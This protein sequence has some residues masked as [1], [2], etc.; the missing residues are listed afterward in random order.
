[1]ALLEFKNCVFNLFYRIAKESIFEHGA[2]L[3]KMDDKAI[4]VFRTPPNDFGLFV[5]SLPNCDLL[6]HVTLKVSIFFKNQ[7]AF[8]FY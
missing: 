1:M 5:F 3:R 4:A 8:L 2:T 7:M 6:S